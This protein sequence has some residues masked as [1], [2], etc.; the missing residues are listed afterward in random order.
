ME[1][2]SICPICEGKQSQAVLICEDYTVSHEKFTIV[3]CSSCGFQ[4][5]N[6][7]PKESEIAK[8]YESDDYVS[9]SNSKKGVIN[10]I[11]QFIRQFSIKKKVK[12]INTLSK[13]GNLLDIGSGTGEFLNAAK[14]NGWIVRGIEPNE[15]AK[16]QSIGNFQL[17]IGSQEDLST[18][19]AASFDIITMW[20]VL[21]HVHH[22]ND[23]V[24][25]L[26]RLLSQSGKV[27]IAVPNYTSADAH[28]YGKN[29][30]AYDVPRHLYHFSPNSIKQLFIK[31]NFTFVKSYPMKFDSYYVSMLTEKNVYHKN[32][33]FSAFLAGITSNLKTKNDAEK[34]SSVIYVF[35]KV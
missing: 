35:A 32:K 27:I 23:R 20:H 30:A 8:Y 33:L 26:H 25:E 7:R 5:T 1:I 2:L 31:H 9:H 22:L 3:A 6:P 13:K 12:M 24:G 11:Y 16:E 15:M 28:H 4:F 10:S 21:E 14:E 18:L 17:N 34:Y 19:A 29:W